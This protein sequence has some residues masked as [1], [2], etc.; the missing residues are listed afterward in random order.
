MRPSMLPVRQGS[1]RQH[2]IIDQS[3]SRRNA[4]ARQQSMRVM[5]GAHTVVVP[6]RSSLRAPVGF[7]SV[8]HT[9]A[10]IRMNG[11]VPFTLHG[12]TPPFPQPWLRFGIAL[13]RG[14]TCFLNFA[15]EPY[16][17]GHCRAAIT[18]FV[19][20]QTLGNQKAHEEQ[21]HDARR[22]FLSSIFFWARLANILNTGVPLAIRL[23]IGRTTSAVTSLIAPC[24]PIQ[25]NCRFS[26]FSGVGLGADSCSG[27]GLPAIWWASES[28]VFWLYHDV[29]VS[30]AIAAISRDLVISAALPTRG[31]STML[32]TGS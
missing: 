7:S 23:V 30:S 9:H 17:S 12:P 32:E 10:V 13:A 16:L 25:R 11:D 3:P 4:C 28:C 2:T 22:P 20:G 31:L 15:A 27:L 21:H 1:P 19:R 24:P 6:L 18:V 5:M 26:S 14:I 29:T 8:C